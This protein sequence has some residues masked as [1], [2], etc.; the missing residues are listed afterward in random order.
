VV[1]D[2]EALEWADVY[3][4]ANLWPG[5][6]YDPKVAAIVNGNGLLDRRHIAHLRGLRNEP[7]T[8]DVAYI[9]NV[10]GGRE[11]SLRVFERLA[12]LDCTKDLLAILLP[13]PRRTKRTPSACAR[14]GSSPASRSP[15]ESSG[16]DSPEPPRPLEPESTSASRGGRS[17]AGHGRVHRLDTLPP[18]RWPV[19]LEA[20]INV[21]D[22]G[23]SRPED[24]EAAPEHDTT[25]SRQRSSGCSAA[26]TSR[27]RCGGVPPRT[28]TS[29]RRRRASAATSSRAWPGGRLIARR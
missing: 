6:S 8:V 14:R 3:F 24:T 4:K 15:H 16:G 11:H 29:T 17:T 18:P 9:S 1:L 25:V 19:Q 23:I 2:P 20:R 12:A 28:S 21:A 7:K 22:C 26:P 27:S 5:H 13:P 10:W